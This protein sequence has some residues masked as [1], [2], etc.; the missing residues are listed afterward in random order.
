MHIA[1]FKSASRFSGG[2]LVRDCAVSCV[3]WRI[4]LK[5][6]A[7][8]GYCCFLSFRRRNPTPFFKTSVKGSDDGNQNVPLSS[9]YRPDKIIATHVKV[10]ISVSVLMVSVCFKSYCHHDL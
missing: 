2:P 5:S 4:L 7:R 6:Q 1:I 10:N 3:K 9:P 8:N